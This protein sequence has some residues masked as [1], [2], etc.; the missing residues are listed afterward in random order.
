MSQTS[1]QP[2]PAGVSRR[3]LCVDLDGT[4]IKSDSLMDSLLVLAR[5]HPLGVLRVPFWLLRGK[6][7]LKE[8]VTAE[9]S[10]DV[11][12][13]PYNRTL[14]EYLEAQRGEGRRLWLATGAD[15]E[16]ATRIADH[17]GIFEG[18]LASDGTTNLT[19]GNKLDGLQ[20]TFGEQ[21]F[22]YIGNAGADLSLLR[23]A[24]TAMIANPS[25]ALRAR[26]RAR[27]VTIE[28]EFDD[29]ASSAKSVLKALR[30]HQWA[31]NILIFMPVL[32]AHALQ[33]GALAEAGIAFLSFSLCASATYIANDLLDIEADRRHPAKRTRPFAAGD[34]P[35]MAG[36]AMSALLL[37]VALAIAVALLP[38]AFLVWLLLY[39]VAT[40]SYS[41]YFKRVVLVDVILLSGLY[42][43]RLL[44]GA[45]ATGQAMTPWL[46]A[47]SLFLFLSLAMVKRLSEL[48]NTRARGQVP[49]SGRGYVLGD[50]EQLRTFGTASAYAAVVVF[51]FYIGAHEV[52]SLYQHPNR[53]WL[54]T[55]LMIY[56]LSRVW[57]LAS[58]GQLDEDPVI[59]A[60]TDRV[61]LLTG[62]AV[63]V[64]AALAAY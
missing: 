62:A 51:S 21:G 37:A 16:L 38:R 53:L 28:R 35:V 34:L 50:I 30:L 42:T 61:S 55:P 48:Q 32:L 46:A 23:H 24:G 29:R 56:W 3:P 54:I 44:A 15:R 36:T 25:P 19:A 41:L 2:A 6:A 14:V 13:L 8:K 27:G 31:K 5:S 1:L 39:L 63:A 49:A 33:V 57:L 26:L 11:R 59:F 45:A 4:L 64:I 47:F 40:L 43:L 7:A 12:H 9:V 58:R 60:V 18:V 22:D 17:L 52:T 10:L 20:S